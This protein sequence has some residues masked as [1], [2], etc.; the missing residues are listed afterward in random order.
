[1]LYFFAAGSPPAAIKI[2]VTALSNGC[3]LREGVMR[4]LRQVQTSNHELV[5]LLGLILFNDGQYPTRVAEVLEREL[6]I[7]FAQS[8]RFK[9][10]TRGAEWFT[11]TPELLQYILGNAQMPESLG[12]PRLVGQRSAGAEQ[13]VAAN[14]HA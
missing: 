10:N 4:R 14:V 2:G 12:V 11:P 6:H 1:M 3:T 9:P 5:E 8:Q 7:K 13:S